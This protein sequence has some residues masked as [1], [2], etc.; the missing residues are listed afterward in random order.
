METKE[1]KFEE[2]DEI[3]D[4]IQVKMNKIINKRQGIFFV[5]GLIVGILVTLLF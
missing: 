5:F 3:F 4:D 1:K 2:I